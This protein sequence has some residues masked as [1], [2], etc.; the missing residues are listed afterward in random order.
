MIVMDSSAVVAILIGEPDQEKFVDIIGKSA[1]CFMSAANL[2]ETRIVL[3]NRKRDAATHILDAFIVDAGAEII[4]V[5]RQTSD[6]AFEAFLRYGKGQGSGAGLNYGDC[7]SYALAKEM[8][9]PLLFKGN[10]FAQTDITAAT[11]TFS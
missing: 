11:E 4:A 2:L 1:L 7:F 9:L 6:I 8:D 10:D 3:F 5:T